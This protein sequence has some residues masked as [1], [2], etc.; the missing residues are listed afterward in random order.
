MSVAATPNIDR[1]RHEIKDCFGSSRSTDPAFTTV[2]C[3]C[4]LEFSASG[5]WAAIALLNAHAEQLN[6][7]R[8][9][10]IARE[11]EECRNRPQE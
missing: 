6:R 2:K 7:A 3:T 9:E 1:F 5:Y 4:G 10:R 11:A 8:A